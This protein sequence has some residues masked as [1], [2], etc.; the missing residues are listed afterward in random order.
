MIRKFLFIYSVCSLFLLHSSLGF[1]IEC[2]KELLRSYNLIGRKEPEE[3]VVEMCTNIELSCCYQSDQIQIYTEWETKNLKQKLEDYYDGVLAHY[4][5]ALNI[6]LKADEMAKNVLEVQKDKKMSNCKLMAERIESFDLEDTLK[7]IL[8]VFEKYKEFFVKSYQGFYC[9]LCDAINH[10]FIFEKTK[11]IKLSS[12][13]CRSMVK[14]TLPGLIYFHD[15]IPV[16]SNLVAEFFNSCDRD[17]EYIVTDPVPKKVLFNLN[18]QVAEQLQLCKQNRNQENWFVS[19]KP[20][21]QEFNMARLVEF[22]GDIK[23]M[24]RFNYFAN[25]KL[26]EIYDVKEIKPQFVELPPFE[27]TIFEKRDDGLLDLTEF[28]QEFYHEGINP[29]KAGDESLFTDIVFEQVKNSVDFK[30]NEGIIEFDKM[31]GFGLMSFVLL[32]IN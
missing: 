5:E 2:N 19:C 10:V 14:K 9:S 1:E 26:N 29:Y 6:F 3:Q 7:D 11:E 12:E 27:S 16:L 15:H 17:G 28:K 31:I 20:I 32:L 21:C 8:K 4:K 24:N 13:Y 30:R 22:N 18:V 25:R 23:T